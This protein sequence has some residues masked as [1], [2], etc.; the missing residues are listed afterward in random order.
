MHVLQ[1][2]AEKLMRGTRYRSAPDFINALLDEEVI[3]GQIIEARNGRTI[4]LYAARP[5]EELSPYELAVSLFPDGYYCNLTAI[6]HH[7]L[8]NQVPNAVYVCHETIQANNRKQTDILSE[9]RIRDAF[10]KPPRHTSFVIAFG[11][12]DLV[13]L[14]RERGSDHGVVEVRRNSSPCPVGSRVAGL[15]RALIDAVVAPHYNGG[16]TSL[17]AYFR[18]ARSHFK[19]EEMLKVYSKLRFVYPYAQS[20]GFFLEH[21]GMR[22]QADRV[23]KSYPPRH[24][25]YVD[26]SAKE[27]W[28]YNERWMVFYPKGLVD[29]D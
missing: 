21:A 5:L 29:E 26:R 14:D 11:G 17:P 2:V 3:Q 22:E 6:Y 16:I 28:T 19:V 8:T 9:S 12:H 23:R 27:S 18:A 25:F 4:S 13:I 24:R 15:E 1:E 10:I 20:I 7:G